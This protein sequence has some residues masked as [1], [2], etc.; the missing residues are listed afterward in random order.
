MI[1]CIVEYILN[2][3]DKV[4]NINGYVYRVEY[5]L[6]VIDKLMNI[7]DYVYSGIYPKCYR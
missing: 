3:K 5:I 2:V 4:M 7:N 6:N 1:T